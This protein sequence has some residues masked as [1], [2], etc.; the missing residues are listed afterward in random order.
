MRLTYCPGRNAIALL[1]LDQPCLVEREI[2]HAAEPVLLLAHG[3]FKAG[4]FLGAGSVTPY[5]SASTSFDTPTTTELAVQQE[6]GDFN[7]DL[8]PQRTVMLEIGARE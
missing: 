4:L 5:L 3:F 7:P 6:G 2:R 1:E 8:D